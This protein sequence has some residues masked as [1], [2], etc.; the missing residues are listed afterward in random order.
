MPKKQKSQDEIIATG[1][2][3]GELPQVIHDAM[4][5]IK[6]DLQGKWLNSQDGDVA[7]REQLWSQLRA[8]DMI[9]NEIRI[10]VQDGVTAKKQK[11]REINK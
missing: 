1:K 8:I 9:E 7:H 2:A 5:N 6:E 11:D 10:M 4:D 3:A